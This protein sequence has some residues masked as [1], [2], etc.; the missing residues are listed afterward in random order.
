MHSAFKGD[1]LVY[2]V[3]GACGLSRMDVEP[4]TAPRSESEPLK[5][6]GLV[7]IRCNQPYAAIEKEAEDRFDLHCGRCGHRWIVPTSSQK[8]LPRGIH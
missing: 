4:P 2:Y 6:T 5:Q 3:C 7:C 1:A 8:D